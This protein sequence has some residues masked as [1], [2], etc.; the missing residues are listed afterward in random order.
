MDALMVRVE[1]C[2]NIQGS[3]VPMTALKAN[4][5]GLS[6]DVDE[7]KSTDLSMLFR[8]MEIPKMW[9]TDIPFYYEVSAA[10]TVGDDA[11]VNEGDVESEVE[12]YEKQLGVRDEAVFYD[13]V[14]TTAQASLRD[15]S[16]IGSSGVKD[17]NMPGTDAETEG[18][19]DMQTLTQS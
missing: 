16:M 6:K 15:I 2:E 9:N 17:A 12:T 13:L 8:T 4:V 14:D 5:I 10:T 11:R 1:E 7:L 19:A 18:V 3:N